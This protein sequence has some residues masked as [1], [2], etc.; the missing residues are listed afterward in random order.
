MQQLESL[1]YLH[2]SLGIRGLENVESKERALEAKLTDKKYL[3][4]LSLAWSPGQ[5]C[6]PHIEMEIIEGLCPPSEL[7]RLRIDGY[8]GR[9]YPSWLSQNQNGLGRLQFLQLDSCSNLEAL[10]EIGEIFIHL[11]ELRLIGLDKI[12]RLPRLPDNLKCLE[13]GGCDSLVAVT[14]VEDVEMIR[15]MLVER[16]SQI[17]PSLEITH[18]EEI[19][20]LA[21]EQPDRFTAIL[22]DAVGV[23]GGHVNTGRR[24]L[25]S[26][27]PFIRGHIREEEYP[28]LLLP[29]SLEEVFIA[30]IAITDTVLQNCLRG[31]TSL[32]SLSVCA[33]PFL[34][35][36]PCEVMKSLARLRYLSIVDCV[37]FTLLQG[38]NDLGHLERL[39]I[40][41]CPN[42]TLQEGEK[43]SLLSEL[44]TDRMSLVPQLLSREACSSL[45][46]LEIH[47]SEEPGGE[48]ILPQLTSLRFLVFRESNL[49]GLPENL[50][51]LTSLGG[52]YLYSC[53]N[54]RS[55]PTLPASLWRFYVLGCDRLFTESCQKVAHIS[56]TRFIL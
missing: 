11:R 15:S 34:R 16:A 55:L 32:T 53:K 21:D 30:D 6:S 9:K 14:C 49:N 8:H 46:S 50:A 4:E 51:D 24:E 56:D 38:L 35:A 45:T 43:A 1:N 41:K 44:T 37:N 22:S 18:T 5:R 42:L 52:L 47:G 19:D 10:P 7:T 3:T 48:E 29:A 40:R 54:I 13:I 2:G 36:M 23:S 20:K 39:T 26:I 25:S 31:C 27:V 28:Q 33:I 12:K 17:E